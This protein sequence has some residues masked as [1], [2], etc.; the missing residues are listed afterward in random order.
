MDPI[1]IPS[2][3]SSF[4]ALPHYEVYLSFRG[5]DT[6]KTFTDHLYSSLVQKGIKTF[7]DDEVLTRRGEDIPLRIMKAIE[8]SRISVIIFSENYASST[9]CL[10][11]LVY[12]LECKERGQ[13]RVVPIFYK[14]DPSDVRNQRGGF[15]QALANHECR[16]KDNMNNVLRWREAL[17]KAAQLS[18]WIFS[19]EYESTFIHKIVE[20]ISVQVFKGNTYLNVAKY[21]IGIDSRVRF[22]F[23]T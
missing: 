21:P 5:E 10:D 2:V 18:G 17:I 1:T 3:F 13:Q 8:E 19:D 7:R 6:G 11:E 16:F 4:P 12:V 20:D 9:F 15:G 14:V 23:R 22:S